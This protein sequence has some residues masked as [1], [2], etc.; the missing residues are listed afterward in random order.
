MSE[1]TL[2]QKTSIRLAFCR[3]IWLIV[4]ALSEGSLC[5][6]KFKGLLFLDLCTSVT[7]FLYAY[8]QNKEVCGKAAIYLWFLGHYFFWANHQLL[9]GHLRVSQQILSEQ[10]RSVLTV[11]CYLYHDSCDR[12]H[13]LVIYNR[14]VILQI[15][16]MD[17]MCTV[18]IQ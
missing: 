14:L 12:N 9:T 8:L 16:N 4:V 7:C 10:K 15:W 5:A 3:E 1:W 11:A 13:V 18:F 6:M 2:W 17:G